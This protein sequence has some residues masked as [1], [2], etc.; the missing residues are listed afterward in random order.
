MGRDGAQVR[1]IDVVSVA[2]SGGPGERPELPRLFL[3]RTE[4]AVPGFGEPQRIE[5]PSWVMLRYR[6]PAP[7]PVVPDPL[8]AVRFSE[9]SPAVDVL[10]GGR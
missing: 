4:L 10:P 2:G 1:E 7:L 3:N 8:A 5:T 9:R 6:V